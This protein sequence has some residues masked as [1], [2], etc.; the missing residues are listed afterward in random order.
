MKVDELCGRSDCSH[1][2]NLQVDSYRRRL[3]R[4]LNANI[5]D[6]PVASRWIRL[7]GYVVLSVGT[8][9]PRWLSD[10]LVHREVAV[11][12]L[13]RVRRQKQSHRLLP[14]LKAIAFESDAV[15]VVRSDAAGFWTEVQAKADGRAIVDQLLVDDLGITGGGGEG[16]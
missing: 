14:Q 12:M 9:Q 13:S 6:G 1:A 4:L 7:N 3:V 10:D 16:E 11:Q 8:G 15:H 2:P 5:D